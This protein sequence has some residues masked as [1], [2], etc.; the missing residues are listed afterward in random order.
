MKVKKSRDQCAQTGI[1]KAA[2]LNI[3]MV[4]SEAV[5]FAKTGGL[6]DVSGALPMAL[7]KAGHQA[8]LIMPAYRAAMQSKFNL[9]STGI[10][11]SIPIGQKS[12]SGS[13]LK[14]KLPGS[15]VPAYFV[16]QDHYFDR[17]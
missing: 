6:A 16:R 14:A 11:F 2:N 1:P 9:E 8:A 10:E 3:L 15:E 13:L 12:V 7:A 17:E 5:P 4:A